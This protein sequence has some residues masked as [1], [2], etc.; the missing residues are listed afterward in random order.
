MRKCG[1]DRQR[2]ER[3]RRAFSPRR[4][5]RSADRRAQPRGRVCPVAVHVRAERLRV[6]SLQ[7]GRAVGVRAVRASVRR[8]VRVVGVRGAPQRLAAAGA[9]RDGRRA[10]GARGGMR[11]VDARRAERLRVGARRSGCGAAVVRAQLG[12]HRGGA[13]AHAPAPARRARH[14]GRR[15]VPVLR[16]L[17]CARPAA[18][19]LRAGRLRAPARRR[20]R[21]RGGP[22][23]APARR[24]AGRRP[25]QR[26]GAD[27][28]GF[29]P[30][31]VQPAVRV[32][33]PVRGGV[34]PVHHV[35]CGPD[36]LVAERNVRRRAAGAGRM[37]RAHAARVA[38]GRAVSTCRGCSWCSGSSSRPRRPPCS[39]RWPSARSPWG[40]QMFSVL[41]WATLAIIAARKPLGR[42]RG[43]RPGL[44]RLEP[45]R[46]DGRRAGASARRRRRRGRR[47]APAAVRA[48]GRRLRRVRMDRASRTSASRQPS[49]A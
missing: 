1:T 20:P 34:R 15:R 11:A 31:A 40:A 33:L 24:A 12:G 45:R 19:R 49:A 46:H 48:R 4:R 22:R 17:P 38:R 36:G 42:H 26:A 6:P 37:V 32:H 3:R 44:L 16:R 5:A 39:G 29:V 27:E 9:G 30:R 13:V 47:R 7:R 25:S 43:P 28:P 21:G 23:R 8:G 18:G 14:H 35:R 41:T 10:G 2:A